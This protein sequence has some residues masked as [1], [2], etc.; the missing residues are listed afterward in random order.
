MQPALSRLLKRMSWLPEI[1][2][3]Q[4]KL[5]GEGNLNRREEGVGTGGSGKLEAGQ[6]MKRKGVLTF[7]SSLKASAVAVKCGMTFLQCGHPV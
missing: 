6:E 5:L 3:S 4:Q 1:P 7:R 2:M